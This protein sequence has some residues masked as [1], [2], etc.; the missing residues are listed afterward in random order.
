MEAD[1][2]CASDSRRAG[3]VASCETYLG[4]KNQHFNVHRHFFF[5]VLD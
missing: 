5:F 1:K 3:K 2:Q 4:Y